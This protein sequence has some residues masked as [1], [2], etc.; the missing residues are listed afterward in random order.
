MHEAI[1]TSQRFTVV[2]IL[3]AAIYAAPGAQTPASDTVTVYEGAR[4]IVGDG[5]APVESSAFVVR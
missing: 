1:T 4:L 2:S 3:A 5:C